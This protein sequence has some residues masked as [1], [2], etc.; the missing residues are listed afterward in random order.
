MYYKIKN[1]LDILFSLILII[2]LM[3]L[4]IIISFLIYLDTKR[5]ILFLQDR[6]GKDGKVFKMIKFRTM[7]IGAEKMGIYEFK[8]DKRVTKVGKFLR[9]T[10]LDEIPQLFNILKG[11]MSFIGPRPVL[12]YHP[13]KYEE[14][15]E[16]QKKRFLVKPGITGLA[17]INGR[18]EI[19]WNKRFEYDIFYVDNLKL[20]LDFK[21]LILTFKNVLLTKNNL[22]TEETVKKN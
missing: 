11:E 13:F 21:I 2:L 18:K 8:N 9:L 20:L 15:T 14:Y 12:T 1:I 7:F 10:S 22:N 6:I 4:F 19:D 3:P 17:Q 5:P 16:M